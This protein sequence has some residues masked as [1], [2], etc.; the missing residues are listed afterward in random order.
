MPR[1]D[2][3]ATEPSAT[4][5]RTLSPHLALERA[6][7]ALDAIATAASD[8][9]PGISLAVDR[10]AEIATE[11]AAVCRR[12]VAEYFE[13]RSP[14]RDRILQEVSRERDRQ[15]VIWDGKSIAS[16]SDPFRCVT[17]LSEEVG[18]VARAAEKSQRA[19]YREELI[20]VAAVAVAMVEAHDRGQLLW[21][22]VGGGR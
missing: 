16:V 7:C 20:Q 5:P 9:T 8:K 11:S 4:A 2:S 6:V 19:N 22:P 21:Q 1:P 18:E 14:A 3:P 17:I 10:V 15:E 13:G 12:T